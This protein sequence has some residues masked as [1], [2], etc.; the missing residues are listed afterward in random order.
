VAP[1]YDPR[2]LENILANGLLD[3]F[4]FAAPSFPVA[5]PLPAA[6]V[7]QARKC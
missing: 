1:G 4:D 5:P 7:D 6:P 2:W 3:L